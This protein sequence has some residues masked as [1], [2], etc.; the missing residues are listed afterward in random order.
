MVLDRYVQRKPDRTGRLLGE[1]CLDARALEVDPETMGK[2]IR[3]SFLLD[4]KPDE[5]TINAL[6]DMALPPSA[7]PSES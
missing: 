6:L 2:L 4:S 3:R 5:E 7:K 1:T